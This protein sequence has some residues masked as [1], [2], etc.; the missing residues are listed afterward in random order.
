MSWASNDVPC[1]CLVSRFVCI[2]SRRIILDTWSYFPEWAIVR[3]EAPA[4]SSL[5]VELWVF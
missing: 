3:V 2:G 4:E 1:C 5:D